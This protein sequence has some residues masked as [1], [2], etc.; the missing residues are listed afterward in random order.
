[1]R[2][3]PEAFYRAAVF[4]FNVGG[5]LPLGTKDGFLG[6]V[7]YQDFVLWKDQWGSNLNILD[8]M[9]TLEITISCMDIFLA[10]EATQMALEFFPRAIARPIE[11]RLKFA[12]G[13]DFFGTATP[14]LA[15]SLGGLRSTFDEILKKGFK[16]TVHV[17][18]GIDATVKERLKFEDWR[19]V[20]NPKLEQGG[21]EGDD[22]AEVEEDVEGEVE[23]EDG[24]EGEG[25][26][27]D[28]LEGQD[29][30]DH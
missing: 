21:D 5:R 8:L 22:E 16:M 7:I 15:C 9:Q 24:D 13:N 18:T 3:L 27:Q 23:H 25:Q 20:L 4:K 1:M 19:Q 30:N 10:P 11:F 17:D 6:A 12:G 29:E 2:E 26:L 28:L 14:M